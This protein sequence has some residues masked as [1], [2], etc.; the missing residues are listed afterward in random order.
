VEQLLGEGRA[1]WRHRP[2]RSGLDFAR[3]AATLGVDRGIDAFQRHVFA[4][5]LGQSPI[6]VPAGRV[7]VSRRDGVDTLAGLD[8]WLDRV[9]RVP[10]TAVATQCRAV[11]QAL[12]VHARTGMA[13]DLASVFAAVGACHE[14]VARSGAARRDTAPLVLRHGETVLAALAPALRVDAALRVAVA[15]AAAHDPGAAATLGGLRPCLSPVG[16]DRGR[17]MWTSG[18]APAALR[19]GFAFAVAEAAR[20]RGFPRADNQDDAAAVRGVRLGFERG[21]ALAAADLTT[22]A[23]GQFDECRAGDLLAGL[24]T[25]DWSS[26]TLT[27]LPGGGPYSRDPAVDL[28]VP[29]T[30]DG[31]VTVTGAEGTRL[32]ALVPDAAWSALLRAGHTG[33]V[34]ADAARRIRI[35][36]LR[37]VI[38]PARS[39]LAGPRLAS[40][41]LARTTEETRRAALAHVAVLPDRTVTTSQESLA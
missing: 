34:L 4:E 16:A 11:E 1:E 6:A 26:V 19:G 24:L 36:G 37:H 35:S 29:F 18:P 32:P 25:V 5:R 3:A 8:P 22:L 2:A 38:S 13:A 12:F 20:R 17:P 30:S 7:R 40:L 39:A 9:R 28:L 10:V 33:R 27:R 14:T 23:T 31:L 41:L 21:P 15:L